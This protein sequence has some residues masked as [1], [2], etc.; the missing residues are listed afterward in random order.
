MWMLD[1]MNIV[2]EKED[3]ANWVDGEGWNF[4]LFLKINFYPQNMLLG[5]VKSFPL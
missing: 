4:L 2:E 1:I 3:S 5:C